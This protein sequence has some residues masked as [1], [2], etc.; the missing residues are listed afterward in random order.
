MKQIAWLSAGLFLITALLVIKYFLKLFSPLLLGTVIAL[1]I[2]PFVDRLE[3]QGLP[4]SIASMLLIGLVL[5]TM[6]FLLGIAVTSLWQ[7]AGQLLEII[8]FIATGESPFAKLIVKVEQNLLEFVFYLFQ[9]LAE[10]FANLPTFMFH[11][12]VIALTAFLLCRDKPILIA[13]L[14]TNAPRSFVRKLTIFKQEVVQGLLAYIKIQL[15]LMAISGGLS[16]VSFFMIQLPYP[17]LLASVVAFLDL[18][19]MVGP[20]WLYFVL[21]MFYII[22]KELLKAVVVIGVWLLISLIRNLW[23]P[24]IIGQQLGLHPLVSLLGIYIGVAI[25]GF[26]GFII[27]PLLMICC[28]S[29]YNLLINPEL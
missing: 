25:L 16:L 12:F 4:R 10:V 23:E 18:I 29:F 1:A 2:Y 24:R 5:I 8:Q 22:H 3:K 9:Q 7:E 6:V 15:F 21:V 17:W 14:L 11:F 26:S 27:G 19:P 13:F 20:N 28:R